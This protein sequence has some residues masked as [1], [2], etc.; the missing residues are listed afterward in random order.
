LFRAFGKYVDPET[1]EWA[2]GVE[3]YG[4]DE[5]KAKMSGGDTDKKDVY[6]KAGPA[7]M[8]FEQIP[9]ISK[10]LFIAYGGELASRYG[11]RE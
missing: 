6:S 10:E 3:Q 5:W 11:V 9:T 8:M 4:E 1:P 2:A 7:L